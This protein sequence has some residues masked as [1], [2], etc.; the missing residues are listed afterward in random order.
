M[1]NITEMPSAG[2]QQG[3]TAEGDLCLQ[4]QWLSDQNAEGE[5]RR[6]DVDEQ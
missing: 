3:A 5:G 2:H 4:L 6:Q 1:E